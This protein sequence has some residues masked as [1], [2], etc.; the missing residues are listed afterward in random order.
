MQ[1][2]YLNTKF[3]IYII[4]YDPKKDQIDGLKKYSKK[5]KY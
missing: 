5:F 1:K 3:K 4:D 2:L